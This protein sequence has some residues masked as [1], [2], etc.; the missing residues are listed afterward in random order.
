MDSI[1][2]SYQCTANKEAFVSSP[3][4]LHLVTSMVVVA[5][6]VVSAVNISAYQLRADD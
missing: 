6:V 1:S 4:S 5:A 3:L 2:T